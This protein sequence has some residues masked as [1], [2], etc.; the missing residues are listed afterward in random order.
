MSLELPALSGKPV[1]IENKRKE[2]NNSPLATIKGEQR[3]EMKL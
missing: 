3:T 2:T 1:G